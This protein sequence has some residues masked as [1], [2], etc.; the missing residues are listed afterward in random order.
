MTPHF[1]RVAIVG[2]GLIGGSVAL[3]L[4]AAHMVDHLVGFDPHAANASQ[5]V[6]LGILDEA[7]GSL[8]SAVRDADLVLLAT[9]PAHV[10]STAL[11]AAAH[12]K[13]GAI[14]T[15]VASIKRAIVEPLADTLPPHVRFVGGHPIA[16]TEKSGAAAAMRELFRGR[17]CILTPTHNTDAQALIAVRAM[18]SRFGAQVLLMT[19]ALHDSACAQ[20]SHLPHVIAYAL[21][22]AIGD[23][24][25][26]LPAIYGLGA[27]GFVDTTRIAS[28][29][30]E[31]WRDVFLMNRDA[32][33]DAV[34]HFTTRLQSLVALVEAGDA[35]G[36]E[37]L[38]AEVREVRARVLRGGGGAGDQRGGTQ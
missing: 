35:R 18:W 20:V 6:E 22:G 7:A 16:G 23:A 8:A 26:R 5:A 36:L 34:E 1:Q 38:F 32:V 28:S 29:S 37:A 17:R 4:R 13:D 31:M 11:A 14:L 3:E 9:P 27:G 24:A 12:A 33:L 2:A 10:V 15:D 25:E 21:T 30:P 19:P